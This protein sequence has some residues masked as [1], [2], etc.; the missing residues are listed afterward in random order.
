MVRAF[1][2]ASGRPVPFVVEA[3]DEPGDVATCY[4]DPQL[5]ADLLGWQARR[6][7][8]ADVRRCLALAAAGQRPDRR[9]WP[10][11]RSVTCAGLLRPPCSVC[12]KKC[13]FDP[14][15]DRLW[16]VGDLV[17]RGPRSLDT[18]RFVRALGPSAITVLGNHDLYLLMTG[19][20]L[21]AAAAKATRSTR[22]SRHPTGKSCS[23]GCAGDRCATA[24]ASSAWCMPACCRNGRPSAPCALAA[25]VE[26]ALSGP[27]S[28]GFA[29]Q[30]LWGSEPAA[31]SDDLHR[32]AASAGDCERDDPDA[33]LFADRRHG[34][35]RPRARSLRRR[36]ATSPGSKFPAA[37]VRPT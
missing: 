6:G 25:E 35:A 8:D 18:L 10:P 17:N 7:I 3:R 4:A 21:S 12:S 36:L 34:I 33:L 16:L 26:A 23:T 19:G 9:A 24:K 11:T 15:S 29:G 28:P 1:A 27:G 13:R 14:P 5:A 37:S 20:R 2:A 32:L 30:P 22:S 31:W